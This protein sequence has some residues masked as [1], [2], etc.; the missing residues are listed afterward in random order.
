M[1][2]PC[3]RA[4][5]RRRALQRARAYAPASRPR[6]RATVALTARGRRRCTLPRARAVPQAWSSVSTGVFI[7]T[8]AFAY[9]C[10]VMFLLFAF[11]LVVFQS[12]VSEE[13]GIGERTRARARRLLTRTCSMACLAA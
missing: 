2:K 9:I 7:G 11:A 5:G 12:A 4:R 1:S 8:I 10:F 3:A 6:S 13:L